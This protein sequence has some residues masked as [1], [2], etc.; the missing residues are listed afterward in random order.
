MDLL[1]K[2]MSDVFLDKQ[3]TL[4]LALRFLR[5]W[6]G[7]QIKDNNDNFIQD[8]VELR[9][10]DNID[11]IFKYSESPIEK[12]FLNALHCC[13][14]IKTPV[15]F[16]FVPPLASANEQIYNYRLFYKRSKQMWEDFQIKSGD[17]SIE[18]FWASVICRTDLTQEVRTKMESF[19]MLEFFDCHNSYFL[20]MQAKLQGLVIQGKTI[21]PDLFIW[22]AS[23]PG[24]GLVV[25]CDGFAYHSD[26]ATFTNDKVRDRLLQSVGFQTFRFSGHE[27]VN[28]PIGKAT[29]MY[30]FL[31][32]EKNKM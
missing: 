12:I 30:N 23:K 4:D 9:V 25:E 2:M 20:S 32:R 29:E 1:G 5:I 18:A 26:R 17:N 13:S 16:M 11:I 27:I 14:L 3:E 21:R 31:I 28:D 7:S 19:A 15:L 24:F 6:L 10:K 8:F 22:I